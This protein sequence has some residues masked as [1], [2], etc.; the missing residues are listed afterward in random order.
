MEYNIYISN[1]EEN[2]LLFK[3][4]TIGYIEDN[5]LT[6]NT[7]NDTIRMNLN[8]F[9]FIKE[10]VESILKITLE[11]CTLTLKELNQSL[12]I[13]IDYINYLNNEKE[14]ILEYKLISQEK[15]LK[16]KIEIGEKHEI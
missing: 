13:P 2:T 10:N 9:S 16:I 1:Y 4:T 14:I 6:Y 7:D 5:Y 15:P 8:N 11:K 3:E 12:E